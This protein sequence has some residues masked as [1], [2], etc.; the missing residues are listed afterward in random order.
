MAEEGFGLTLVEALA[1]GVPCAAFDE[2]AM[3][4]IIT[5]G[6]NG[7]IS[8][9]MTAEG[10]AKAIEKVYLLWKND[11]GSYIEMCKYS[12]ISAKRFELRNTLKNLESLY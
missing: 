2:G 5:D 4:E 8:K 9:K 1:C 10:L 3:R 6:K 7:F 12:N 11:Y